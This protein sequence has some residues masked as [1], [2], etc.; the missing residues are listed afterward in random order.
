MRVL[1]AR[2]W[3]VL[4]AIAG[5]AAVAWLG[6]AS[7]EHAAARRMPLTGEWHVQ[8]VLDS[9]HPPTWTDSLHARAS[10]I[11]GMVVLREGLP[12]T[13]EEY[14]GWRTVGFRGGHSLPLAELTG[15]R[16]SLPTDAIALRVGNDSVYLFLDGDCCD[17]HGIRAT[18]RIRGDS[19]DGRWVTDSDGWAAWGHF[20]M[21]RRRGGAT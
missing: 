3:I 7:M 13:R 11:E 6:I 15:T 20:A 21:S 1:V 5:V 9:L 4:A 18:G 14:G 10:R 16:G 17:A 12:G 19:A 8:L 2:P